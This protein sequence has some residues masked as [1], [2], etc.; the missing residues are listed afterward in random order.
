MI[1]KVSQQPQMREPEPDKRGSYVQEG[2]QSGRSY[3]I[4]P[5]TFKHK[6]LLKEHMQKLITENTELS[7]KPEENLDKLKEIKSELVKA[8]DAAHKYNKKAHIQLGSLFN[9]NLKIET[10]DKEIKKLDDTIRPLDN[11]KKTSVLIEELNRNIEN[12][13]KKIQNNQA[14]KPKDGVF[15]PPAIAGTVRNLLKSS[16]LLDP[17]VVKATERVQGAGEDIDTGKDIDIDVHASAIKQVFLTWDQQTEKREINLIQKTGIHK[18]IIKEDTY[19]ADEEWNKLSKEGK[20]ARVNT[21]IMNAKKA[22]NELPEIEK[23]FVKNV[24]LIMVNAKENWKL[25]PKNEKDSDSYITYKLLTSV[26]SF[27]KVFPN[28]GDLITYHKE[29]FLT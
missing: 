22:W 10:Y 18:I 15:R 13:N 25:N 11:M 29:I 19:K 24:V 7:K 17:N 20:E 12:L 4:N 1:N 9:K 8:N 2:E 3:T 23:E 21:F 16:G 6:S 26:P 5:E 28:L 27:T 14:P